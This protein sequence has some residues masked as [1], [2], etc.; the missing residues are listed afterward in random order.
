MR[1]IGA[2]QEP[3]SIPIGFG[4]GGLLRIGSLRNRLNTLAAAAAN[5]I[6]HFDTAPIYGF[7]ESERTLGRFLC[8]QRSRLTLATKFGLRAS[9]MAARLVPLQ[10][11]ARRT[12]Q[13]FP[14]LRRAATRNS[15]M[16]YR[17]PNFDLAAARSSLH[18]SLQAL[19]TDYV[20]FLL[21][22]QASA[23]ALPPEEVIGWLQDLKREG[24]I[25]GFGVATEY[26]YLAPVLRQ[27]PQLAQ[28]VQFDSPLNRAHH[29][30]LVA[31]QLQ[32]TFGLVGRAIESCRGKLP[33]DDDMLGAVLL[34]A[35]VLA[36]PRG[37]VL[38]QSRS[39]AR[40]EL[41]V[42][43]ATQP[44]HDE[45]AARVVTLLKQSTR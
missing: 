2:S 44:A 28:V 4:T 12:L 20:D 26:D 21:A 37:I 5:G 1:G 9:P 22:H 3:V 25:R 36:N 39:P 8:G 41:N 19:R 15:G 27:R 11:V 32:I 31:G 34:R 14:A 18:G 45:L 16:L 40:I 33:V 42:R 35:A 24:T 29:L 23:T 17:P 30:E 43:V 38:M 13:M 7:G 6:T 10:R